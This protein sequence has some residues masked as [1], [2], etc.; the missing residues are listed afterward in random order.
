VPRHWRGI[1][2]VMSWALATGSKV[3]TGPPSGIGSMDWSMGRGRAA[4]TYGVLG[5]GLAASSIGG[6][7]ASSSGS[8]MEGSK[9]T[10]AQTKGNA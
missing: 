5:R 10:K 4:G 1:S 6:L 9:S 2:E 7:T 8:G 3:S